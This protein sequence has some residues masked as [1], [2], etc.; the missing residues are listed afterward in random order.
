[1]D[2]TTLSNH[3]WSS[4]GELQ[5]NHVALLNDIKPALLRTCHFVLCDY[6]QCCVTKSRNSFNRGPGFKIGDGDARV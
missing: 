1:M 6:T 5:K 3:E 2:R 4:A